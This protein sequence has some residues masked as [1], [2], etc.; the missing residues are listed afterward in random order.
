MS[1]F[2][3]MCLFSLSMSLTPGPVNLI[4]L[5]TGSHYGFKY[6]L[7]FVSGATLGFV[8]LLLVV[9]LGFGKVLSVAP[10]LQQILALAGALFILYI[11]I[12]LF[13]TKGTPEA[14]S[15]NGASFGSGFVLQWLNPKAWIACLTGISAFELTHT[16]QLIQFVL[17]YFLICFP[18]IASWAWA[19]ELV[20]THL[21]SPNATR[22]FNQCMGGALILLSIYLVVA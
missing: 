6:A 9:G 20:R 5:A 1:L 22:V 8:L 19:G 21:N 15:S 13:R 4:A 7:R 18:C 14:G 3:A 11:G 16:G 17:L 10:G 12:T 2:I